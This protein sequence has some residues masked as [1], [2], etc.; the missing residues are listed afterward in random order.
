[1]KI[2]IPIDGSAH[3][4]AA[5][6]H[7]IERVEWYRTAVTVDLVCVRPPLSPR[8]T[9]MAMSVPEL[10]DC[11]RAEANGSLALAKRMLDEA[12]IAHHQHIVVGDAAEMIVEQSRKAGA[13]L[14]LMASRGMGGGVLL[15]STAVKVLHLSTG[16]PVQVVHC[17]TSF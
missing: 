14:I 16:V 8:L 4:A 12:G 5:I 9:R 11:Y 7:L 10:E 13:D 1:M 2:L 15:G 6:E 17:R 3:S